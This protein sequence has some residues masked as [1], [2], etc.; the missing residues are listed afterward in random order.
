VVLN[1]TLYDIGRLNRRS[2]W[3]LLIVLNWSA[4]TPQHT[5]KELGAISEFLRRDDIP[6]TFEAIYA[7]IKPELR[8]VWGH[9]VLPGGGGAISAEAYQTALVVSRAEIRRRL[10]QAFVGHGAEAILQPTFDRTTGE[11]PYRGAGGQPPRPGQPHRVG[12]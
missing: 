7:D 9:M 3:L 6:T 11:L 5:P 8:D 10:D 12:E 1:W 4:L 2:T